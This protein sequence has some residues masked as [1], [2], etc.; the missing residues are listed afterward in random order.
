MKNKV[1]AVKTY[2]FDLAEMANCVRLKLREH[3]KMRKPNMEE[4]FSGRVRSTLT[5]QALDFRLRRQLRRVD[6][7]VKSTV[8]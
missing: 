7:Y 3:P 5:C 8:A 2:G 6:L 1:Y 4:A